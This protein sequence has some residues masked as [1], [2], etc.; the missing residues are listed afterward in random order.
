MR[1]IGREWAKLSSDEKNEYDL[2]AGDD[3]AHY[4]MEFNEF[5]RKM[6]IDEKDGDDT[7]TLEMLEAEQTFSDIDENGLPTQKQFTS[8]T[9]TGVFGNVIP[10]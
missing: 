10:P 4:N 5:K 2:R 7:Q 3:R 6:D 8:R 1:L 9:N